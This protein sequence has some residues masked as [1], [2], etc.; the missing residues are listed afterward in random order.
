M[1]GYQIKVTIENTKPPV[2]RRLEIPNQITF[3]DL[4][5]ML[6]EVFGWQEMHLHGFSFQNTG[7]TVGN[8]GSFDYDENELLA[9]DFLRTGWIRYTYDYGDDWRHKIILEKELPDYEKRYSRVVKF[10]GN[11]FEEDSGGVWGADETKD[12]PMPYDLKAVNERLS[13]LICP[14][15]PDAVTAEEQGIWVNQKKEKREARAKLMEMF[16]DFGQLLHE[17]WQI[18]ESAPIDLLAEKTAEAWYDLEEQQN[19]QLGTSQKQ[20]SEMLQTD[21]I[22]HLFELNKY[23]AIPEK[24]QVPLTKNMA[25]EIAAALKEHPEYLAY[26]FSASDLY[27]YVEWFR[28]KEASQLPEHHVLMGFAMLGLTELK[29]EQKKKKPYL[30]IN[31]P[32]D[33]ESIVTFLEKEKPENLERQPNRIWERIYGMLM[34]YGYIEIQALY[35]QYTRLFG[36]ISREDFER[37]LYLRGRFR[38]QIVTGVKSDEARLEAWAAISAEA[39]EAATEAVTENTTEAATEVVTEKMPETVSGSVGYKS[40]SRKQVLEMIRLGYA[41]VYPQWE[42]LFEILCHMDFEEWEAEDI[43]NIWYEQV[44]I[45]KGMKALLKEVEEVKELMQPEDWTILEH[46]LCRCWSETGIALLKGYSRLEIAKTTGMNLFAVASEDGY[47]L[48]G[49]AE[50]ELERTDTPSPVQV[51]P[52]A[53]CPCGSGKRYRQCC[54]RKK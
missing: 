25:E 48:S 51:D 34:C 31:L 41:A 35:E 40:F 8:E 14:E 16:S 36:E 29:M 49:Y 10:K 11:N 6:Q 12:E 38:G 15:Q 13:T 26:M 2:W 33:A 39:A 54:G 46:A 47:E 44:H 28:K 19:W 37:C 4:H 1:S 18:G 42:I 7:V 24:Q 53:V 32:Q 23:F 9:D 5:D 21:G 52:N 17:T 30:Y 27:Q 3:R 50:K 43:L 22:R 20:M 45:G